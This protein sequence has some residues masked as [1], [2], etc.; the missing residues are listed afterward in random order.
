LQ[1]Q[2]PYLL[3]FFGLL[4]SLMAWLSVAKENGTQT[5]LFNTFN[6]EEADSTEA[7]K[8]KKK[9]RRSTYKDKDR[10]GDAYSNKPSKSPLLLKDP[11]NIKKDVEIGDDTAGSYHV[12]EKIGDLDYRSPS[13]MSYE[14]FEK[15]RQEEAAQ[16]YWKNKK[17]PRVGDTTMGNA[18]LVPKIV[19]SPTMDRIFGGNVIDIK[20]NGNVML[21]FGGQFQRVDKPDTPVRLQRMG[22]FIFNQTIQLNVQ[23]K[24]GEKLKLGLNWDTKATFDFENNLKIDYN[25]LDYEIIKKI[26]AGNISFPLNSQLIQGSQN[27]FGVR[28]DLQFGKLWV[29]AVAANQRG[30]SDELVI[31]NNAQNKEIE[32]RADNYEDN[33]H[34]FL[35]QYF[36][37]NYEKALQ[38]LPLVNSGIKIANIIDVYV[39]NRN[40]TI[41]GAR[42]I[43]AL[44]DLGENTPHDIGNSFVYMPGNSNVLPDNNSNNIY[45]TVLM[46]NAVRN[47]EMANS[48]LEGYG[49]QKVA[50]YET[51]KSARKLTLGKDYTINAQLGYISLNSPLRNDDVLAVAY[52]YTDNTTTT[53]AVHKVGETSEQLS[54]VEKTEAIILKL[55]RP[56]TIRT[57]LPMW[58]LQMKNIYNIN[59]S[60]VSKK[61][62]QFR[63]IYK[64]D[65]SGIDNPSIHEGAHLANKPLLQ[66]FNLDR[67]NQNN[68]PQPDGN[69]DFIPSTTIDTSAGR[70]IFP[71]LEPFGAY[72]ASKFDTT[73]VNL[74]EKYAFKEIYRKTKSDLLNL[75]SKNKFFLRVA[76]SSSSSND[77][78]LPGLNISRGSVRITAGSTPLTEG[79][80]YTVNYE[81]GRIKI[82]N[83]G[84]M[85]SAREIRIKYEKADLFNFRQ[86]SLTG[87]RF[88]YK[89]NKDI[90]LGGT[91]L[92]LNERPLITRVSI[93]DE[94]VSNTIV[95][96]DL[97]YQRESRTITKLIDKLPLI[98]T[99]VPSNVALQGEYAAFIPGSSSLI[100]S[101]GTAYLDDFEGAENPFDLT[102]SPTRWKL[103][104]TP[105]T[106]SNL[107]TGQLEFGYK[108]AKL[109]WYMIDNVFYTDGGTNKPTNISSEDIKNHYVRAVLP[110]EIY[111]NRDQQQAQLNEPVFDLN[112]Y[113]AERGP[114]NYNPNLNPDGTI[115]GD[116]KLNFGSITRSITTDTDF[117][118]ANIQYLEFWLMDPFISDKSK[119]GGIPVKN[120]AGTADSLIYNTTGGKMYIHLGNVSED[121]LKDGQQSFENGLP[122]PGLSTAATANI[123]GNIPQGNY[124]NDAFAATTGARPL[125]DI[126]LDGVKNTEEATFYG[127]SFIDKIP[128]ASKNA[129]LKDPSADD[130]VHYLDNSNADKN[131]KIIDRYKHYNGLENNSPENTGGQSFTPSSTNS[132][133]NEDL[134]QNNTINDLEQYFEYEID[135][136]PNKLQGSNKYIIAKEVSIQNEDSVAWYQFR[137]PIRDPNAKNINNIT[138]LKSIRYLRMNLTGWSQPVAL[139]M[140][141]LQLV[142]GQWRTFFPATD[143]DEKT[144]EV[145]PEPINTAF[146]ISTV[147]IEENSQGSSTTSGYTVPPGFIRDRDNTSNVSR[148]LNEQ[149]IRMCVDNLG[150]GK[151]RAVF[152][153]TNFNFMNYGKL[154]MFI[155]A[156]SA[157]IPSTSP[158]DT[159]L[160][161]FIRLGTDFTQ[162]YYEI[163]IPLVYTRNPTVDD[164]EVWRWENNVDISFDALSGVKA[165]R[166]RIG[167]YDQRIAFSRFVENRNVSIV[168]N[169]DL[170]SIQVLMLGL[171]NPITKDQHPYSA[172][173]WMDEFRVTDFVNNTGHAAIGRANAKLAD[174]ATVSL[175]GK[176]MGIGFGSID[177]KISQ[178]NLNEQIDYG[179]QSNVSL[180]KLIPEKAGLKIPLFVSYDRS[181]STPKYDPTN[182][183]I[184]LDASLASVEDPVKRESLRQ[185][186]IDQSTKRSINITN[187][188]KVKT[189]KNPK[190]HLYDVENLS[191]SASYSD[192]IRTSYLIAE[193]TTLQYKAGIRYNFTGSP[194]NLEPLK[195]LNLKSPY[196]AL[197]KDFNLTLMPAMLSFTADVNR[198]YN[199]MQNRNSFLGID[200]VDPQYQKA[201]TFNRTYGL[202]WALTKSLSLNYGA[203]VLA[204]I[205]EE[206][207]EINT[208]TNDKKIE[209]NLKKGGRLQRFD[210]NIGFNYKIPFNKLPF[211]DWLSADTRY[212]AT[213]LWQ[214]ASL[215]TADSLGNTITN[216][217]EKSVNGRI[218]LIKLY[219]KVK[220]LKE[221]NS[222]TPPKKPDPKDTIKPKPELKLVKGI[223]RILMTAKSLN[224]TYSLKEGTAVPGFRPKP[225]YLGMSNHK[226]S[227]GAFAP[228]I[229]FLLGSQDLGPF[230]DQA[231]ANNWISTN[232]NMSAQMGQNYTENITL[233]TTLE[234]FKDFKVQL[235]AKRDRTG[236][237]TETYRYDQNTSSFSHYSPVRSG[238]YNIS[239]IS[240]KTSFI[241]DNSSN[242]SEV[243]ETFRKNREIIKSRL[244]TLNENKNSAQYN[245]NSQDVLI[246]A[247]I[248]A[249]TGADANTTKLTSFPK[250]PLPN[251][252]ID[253][254]GLSSLGLVKKFFSTVSLTHKYSSLYSIGAYNNS[255]LYDNSFIGLDHSEL[256]QPLASKFSSSLNTSSGSAIFNP[257]YVIAGVSIKEAFSPLLGVNMKTKKNVTIKLEYRKTRDINLSLS[258]FQ[259]TE[260]GNN[261]VVIGF[262][263]TKANY[264]IP[265]TKDFVLKNDLTFR[266]DTRISDTK[267]TQRTLEGLNSVTSGNLLI[268]IKPNISYVVNQRLNLQFY[269][270]HTINSPKVSNSFYRTNTLFGIQVRFTLS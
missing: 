238:S 239:F 206:F 9:T 8:P 6:P 265:F 226:E 33:R 112:F 250:I 104:S 83:E 190:S 49:L 200:G 115:N 195:G 157:T 260:L 89:Y 144:A 106:M 259:V 182:P 167:A 88:D 23:G 60:N 75:A 189:G 227:D 161:A 94:P 165:A 268:S 213:Y 67:L 134:N 70:I 118:N 86:K 10:Y 159:T 257:I 98:V 249:Y 12:T 73:E 207:G 225:V 27:L 14:E 180:D 45:S 80:D 58:N 71:V 84:V 92:H 130:F 1:I 26:D 56:T 187:L 47:V 171:K 177:Q 22:Q 185:I 153:N 156:E 163:E 72:L 216:A 30:K 59:Q 28:A 266:F 21:D 78:A 255:S 109:A 264:K 154:Q 74:I 140:A 44:M 81:Q 137:I 199:K 24:V 102:R 65:A 54:G 18:R 53:N 116:P 198:S 194:K 29:S 150:D 52:N 125:Q 203:N 39:T 34:Y 231:A 175:S 214:G 63:I 258:N 127:K 173:V 79:T 41:E 131:Y 16:K 145:K 96:L 141:Q 233:K 240:I 204:I 55:L 224:F 235:D 252:Q 93:G 51:V 158:P 245:I 152:K 90:V 229:P 62:F 7:L 148:R 61:N 46:N 155:H 111:P 101:S 192:G 219:N 243:F 196:L 218:D 103:G 36:R 193:N 31:Q 222:P 97:T 164:N 247:F 99:K 20:P 13:E 66:V 166:N 114:Y 113:P 197:I 57:D 126:G 139:R 256:D 241:S 108:R 149:S 254:S 105:I 77:I 50:G 261:E 38:N 151:A 172:C 217:A 176:Y 179:V 121:V 40:N 263:F 3:L 246:P 242:A 129:V 25:G 230:L 212:G 169:P 19:M 110:Q 17:D 178:R 253:Y 82:L 100:G 91:I 262:G 142:A 68:D 174:F 208:P 35:A 48:I 117:D 168:G 143:L 237:Y 120:K 87:A 210:Q 201:F 123:W 138:D 76:S 220:F 124:I 267:T 236:L 269:F 188:S 244:T 202:N 181:T 270:D 223:F 85:A 135:L 160:R 215:A 11:T 119:H 186:L 107:G 183:D 64:D 4:F 2:K 184:K 128:D 15:H 211:T 122:A 133:D 136:S 162:N 205:D 132:P 69:F 251:W 228:G 191:L 146:N 32:F 170:S 232:P 147:N 37:N 221:I 95:G 234:P 209:S 5:L 43:I 42:N 248:A